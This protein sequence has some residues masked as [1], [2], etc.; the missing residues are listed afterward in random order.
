MKIFNP[1]SIIFKNQLRDLMNN[2]DLIIREIKVNPVKP[3]S[4]SKVSRCPIILKSTL[5]FFRGNLVPMEKCSYSLETIRTNNRFI[6]SQTQD[7]IKNVSSIRNS[8]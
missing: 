4:S 1:D 5:C 8:I 7:T 2:I 6:Y 3:R